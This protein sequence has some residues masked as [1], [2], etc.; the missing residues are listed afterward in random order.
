MKS[1]L[2]LIFTLHLTSAVTHSLDF[3]F[4]GVTPGTSFPE[5]TAVGQVDGLQGGYF[6]S[7]SNNVTLQAE[8]IKDN[9]D[10]KHWNLITQQACRYRK[11]FKVSI[12][13]IMHRFSHTEGIHTWQWMCGCELQDNGTRRGY[14]RYGYDGEDFISLDLNTLTWTAANAKAVIIKQG[15]KESAKARSHKSFLEYT[16]IAWLQKYVEYGR[17]TLERKGK[18]CE[19]ICYCADLSFTGVLHSP[20]TSA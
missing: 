19:L 9:K 4:T 17:A 18:V 12:D 8:W 20:I 11:A 7:N 13:E 6:D 3:F 5:F 16:C 1:L 15:W 10:E 2:L 14:S